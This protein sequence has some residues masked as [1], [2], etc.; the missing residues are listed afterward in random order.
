MSRQQENG[1]TAGRRG[2]WPRDKIRRRQYAAVV[3]SGAVVVAAALVAPNALAGSDRSAPGTPDAAQPGGVAGTTVPELKWKRCAKTFRC[4]TAKVP[5][6]YRKPHGKTI[7]LALL[8]RP[9]G[10]QKNKT[11]TVFFNPGGPGES[12]VESVMEFGDKLVSRPA[13]KK[14]D[15]VG[16]DP[17]G[18][19]RSTPLRCFR[20]P[21]EAA[22]VDLPTF[23]MKPEQTGAFMAKAKRYTELCKRNDRKMLTHMSTGTVARDLD[24]LRAAVGDKKLTYYGVSYGTYLGTVYGNMF[25]DRVRALA[26]EGVVEPKGY[27]G[28][29]I[30]GPAIEAD[31]ASHSTLKAFMRACDQAGQ[32]ACALADDTAGGAQRKFDAVVERLSAEPVPGKDGP[33]GHPQLLDTVFEGLLYVGGWSALAGQLEEM[34][35]Q[36][37]EGPGKNNPA[38]GA[39]IADRLTRQTEAGEGQQDDPLRGALP[40][41]VDN[42]IAAQLGIMCTDGDGSRDQAAWPR[43]AAERD[44][45]AP[46]F[47]SY[48]TFGSAQCATWP[49][50]DHDRYAGNFD[51]RTASPA[52]IVNATLDPST[53]HN[54][55]VKLARIMPGAHLLTLNGYGHANVA[56]SACKDE[57]TGKYLLT[58]QLKGLPR[59]CEQDMK[60]FSADGPPKAP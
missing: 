3:L 5:L 58:G 60:P 40:P 24:L 23:P 55:A 46:G 42:S 15:L 6:D 34:H 27:Q 1:T 19:S 51:A 43:T 25:P 9:A 10:D 2:L 29:S 59:T 50:K 49:G 12:G 35:K 7:K 26:L 56:T 30:F 36:I 11:G 20:T 8:K 16:F 37:V 13:L 39:A 54:S 57:A 38:A 14:F 21:D 32:R 45:I 47:G 28:G 44:K 31:R 17:R 18:V 4:A 53:H 41:A 48:W 22:S 33:Y 52:L